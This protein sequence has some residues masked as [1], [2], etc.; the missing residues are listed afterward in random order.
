MPS[1]VALGFAL[2]FVGIAVNVVPV[3]HPLARRVVAWGCYLGAV[4]VLLFAVVSWTWF[5]ALTVGTVL[6]AAGILLLILERQLPAKRRTSG[7]NMDKFNQLRQMTKPEPLPTPRPPVTPTRQA[8]ATLL[9]QLL[10]KG[11]MLKISLEYEN[12]LSAIAAGARVPAD[13]REVDA[14]KAEVVRTLP[15]ARLEARFL[16]QPPAPTT[17]AQAVGSP[18]YRRL[19]ALLRNLEGIIKEL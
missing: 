6:I 3:N 10:V 12:P 4:E 13:D 8:L 18:L 7:H 19:D 9:H 14:W 1:G 2:A 16:K 5:L 17:T 15:D 11:E